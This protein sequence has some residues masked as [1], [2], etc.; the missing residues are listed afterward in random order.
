MFGSSTPRAASQVQATAQAV[1]GKPLGGF[2]VYT[3]VS[4]RF[5]HHGVRM[6]IREQHQAALADLEKARQKCSALKDRITDLE[7]V[8]EFKKAKN[9]VIRATELC[10]FFC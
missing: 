3:G 7:S 1:E 9:E 5:D 4:L 2:C 8:S 10:Q 6:T